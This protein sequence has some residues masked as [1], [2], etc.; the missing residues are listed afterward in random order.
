MTQ[1]ACNTNATWRQHCAAARRCR[2][3]QTLAALVQRSKRGCSACGSPGKPEARSRKRAGHASKSVHARTAPTGDTERWHRSPRAEGTHRQEILGRAADDVA[4][5]ETE[6]EPAVGT[7]PV[8]DGRIAAVELAPKGLQAVQED[9]VARSK[10]LVMSLQR[11][12][13]MRRGEARSRWRCVAQPS[14]TGR[15]V[16]VGGAR[17]G[18]DVERASL[19]LVN[20]SERRAKSPAGRP[21][22]DASVHGA[23]HPRLAPLRMWEADQREETMREP[24]ASRRRYAKTVATANAFD[25]ILTSAHSAIADISYKVCAVRSGDSQPPIT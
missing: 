6:A 5:G 18:G 11:H 9:D 21:T 20:V 1:Y 15:D 25:P 22:Q 3:S 10:P 23:L 7:R 12:R 4:G 16:D 19:A 8:C 14:P 13:E 24:R 17:P 2:P